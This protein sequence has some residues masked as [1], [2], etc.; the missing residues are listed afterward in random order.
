MISWANPWSASTNFFYR[1][2]TFPLYL[3][4]SVMGF[5]SGWVQT[6]QVRWL[7]LG[8]PALVLAFLIIGLAMHSQEG[9]SSE[10]VRRYIETSQRHLKAGRI[11]QAE[12]FINRLR[13][14]GFQSDQLLLTRAEIATR[15]E[16]PDLAENC[17]REMLT[18]SD[19][20][21]DPLAHRELAFLSMK[22]TIDPQ[23]LQA[24]E[25]IEHLESA[26]K[27]N[28]GDLAVHEMLTKL[29]LM[30][31]DFQSAV[32]HLEPVAH[33][34]PAAML[35]LA[36]L[37]EKFGR[38][39]KKVDAA[40]KA[41]KYF[42]A[43]VAA[44]E[45]MPSPVKGQSEAQTIAVWNEAVLSWS[46]SLTMQ[47]KLDE[48]IQA[49]TTGLERH[50]TPELRKRLASIYVR[51]CQALPVADKTWQTRWDLVTLSRNYDPDSQDSMTILADIASHAPFELR[52][53]A[54]CELQPYLDNGTAPPSA[55]YMVGTVAAENQQWD[56]A[57]KLLRTAVQI[58]PRA[59]IAWNNLAFA[60]YSQPIPNWKEA[61]QIVDEAIRLNPTPVQYHETRGQIMVGLE[62]WPEVVREL[63]YALAGMPALARI[64][65]GL[66]LAYQ[67]LGDEDLADYH[68]TREIT[69]KQR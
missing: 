29:F 17:Y 32:R 58:E 28:P 41:E 54:L 42:A 24:T 45:K 15:R 21:Q 14:L 51:K 22:S 63:E 9:L 52:Q 50:E 47:A 60:L 1:L 37:Y 5:A 43:V 68:R 4:W 53:L 31:E 8:I 20:T 30:R 65:G 40:S 12:F 7:M 10:T 11:D 19:H 62:R 66:A 25:A 36:R 3:A 59:G 26:I 46:E 18:N 23:S 35:E 27:A 38:S 33:Q 61:E 56:T 13:T 2:R 6:R 34:N 44:I 16:R 39:S 67:Q 69:L 64:H 48:A 49:V 57:I 55:Y